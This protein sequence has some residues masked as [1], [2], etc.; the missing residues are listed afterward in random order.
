MNRAYYL[1]GT[2][3]NV[4]EIRPVGMDESGKTKYP[5]LLA[6]SPLVPSSRP[7]LHP[8]YTVNQAE[9]IL[10]FLLVLF[11]LPFLSSHTEV[12]TP[13]PSTCATAFHGPHTSPPSSSTSYSSSMDVERASRVGT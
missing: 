7:C 4:K 3:L 2:E 5:I 8:F 11:L 9:Y 12:L 1:S 10:S 6:V 13:S